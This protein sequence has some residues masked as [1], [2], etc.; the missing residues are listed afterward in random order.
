MPSEPAFASPDTVSLAAA[1]A[2]NSKIA[3]T[4][5]TDCPGWETSPVNLDAPVALDEFSS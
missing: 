3:R 1:Q 2:T 4:V 5:K